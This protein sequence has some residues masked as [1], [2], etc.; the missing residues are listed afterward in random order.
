MIDLIHHD[1]ASQQIGHQPAVFLIRRDQFACQS[2]NPHFFQRPRLS[3]TLAAFH[4]GQR[5]KRCTAIPVLFQMFNQAFRRLLGIRHN[6]L[7]TA[8]KCRLDRR[9]IFLRRADQIRHNAMNTRNAVPDFHHAADTAAVALV[10]LRQIPH[11]FQP[12][13]VR[14]V[15]LLK[16]RKFLVQAAFLFFL[17]ARLLLQLFFLR[18]KRFQTFPHLP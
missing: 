4:A 12:R 2:K 11:R 17:R 14:V 1:H 5:Q 18:R 16:A 3:K 13:P 15:I 9:L 8:A 6:V 10:A 7:D